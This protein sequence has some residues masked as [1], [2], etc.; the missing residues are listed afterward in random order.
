MQNNAAHSPHSTEAEL[1]SHTLHID[2]AADDEPASFT[3]AR[4][5]PT[6]LAVSVLAVAVALV[7]A[8]G[9]AGA[10]ELMGDEASRAWKGDKRVERVAVLAVAA[11][12]E[13]REAR[14]D[15]RWPGGVGAVVRRPNEDDSSDEPSGADGVAVA[16]DEG[17][18]RD[19][20]ILEL[21]LEPP[22]ADRAGTEEDKAEELPAVA[23]DRRAD[24]DELF[25]DSDAPFRLAAKRGGPDEMEKR[26][27]R[28]V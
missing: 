8:C 21:E 5:G 27:E 4:A 7:L 2:A 16:G 22:T 25:I 12:L 23:A 13:C 19:D 11:A 26:G 1:L 3:A 6:V 18:M 24:N 28:G 20:S 14:C 9:A 10:G 15:V 17:R